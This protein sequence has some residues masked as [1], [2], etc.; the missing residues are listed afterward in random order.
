MPVFGRCVP[1]SGKRLPAKPMLK[2]PARIQ[3]RGNRGIVPAPMYENV[4]S[5]LRRPYVG[6]R[7]SPS[8]CALVNHHRRP[9]PVPPR[10]SL[11]ISSSTTAP[12]VALTIALMMPA[13][14][15]MPSFGSNQLPIKAPIIPIIRSPI[16]PNPAPRTSWPASPQS[17]QL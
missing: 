4:L 11:I 8:A 6:G 3:S 1:R 7:S 15:R 13:P 9:Q 5:G 12:I 2:L 17:P 16:S 10:T 14:R